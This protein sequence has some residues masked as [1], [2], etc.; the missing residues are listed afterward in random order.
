VLSLCLKHMKKIFSA[1]V[2][3]L[4][5]VTVIVIAR[6]QRQNRAPRIPAQELLIRDLDGK[7][8][9]LSDFHGK[10]LVVNFWG[11]WCGPCRQEFPGFEKV[12]ARLSGKVNFLMI[13]DEPV[14][15]IIRF[16]DANPYGF[17]YARSEKRFKELGIS[18]VPVSYF[19]DAEGTLVARQIDPLE[20]QQLEDFIEQTGK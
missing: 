12:R 19:Y 20:E 9:R 10:P 4:L 1:I 11:S 7:P 2:V 13:S 6:K 18:S 16:R 15:K 17:V 5:L 8:V 3:A 14:E